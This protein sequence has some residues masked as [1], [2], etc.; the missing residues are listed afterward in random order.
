MSKQELI[1]EGYAQIGLVSGPFDLSPEM[2]QTGLTS[3]D[4]MMALLSIQGVRLGYPLP[5]QPGN[6]NLEDDSR[7]PDW[8][9]MAVTMKLGIMLASKRGKP[10]SAQLLSNADI[11]YSAMLTELSK[12]NEMRLP[13]QT[14]LG[15]GNR[16]WGAIGR[17][18]VGHQGGGLD[19][20]LHGKGKN[21]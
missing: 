17:A 2:L 11:A 15:A 8:A 7:L 18:F 20:T 4:S 12:D 3:L 13:A 1:E 5:S 10:V 6:S 21:Q 16:R 19:L 14:P 9:V